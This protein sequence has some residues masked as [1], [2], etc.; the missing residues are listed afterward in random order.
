MLAKRTRKVTRRLKIKSMPQFFDRRFGSRP[1]KLFCAT[2]IF[3]FLLPY[4]A[5]VYKGLTSV[6]AVLLGVDERVCMIVIAL[7]AAAVVVLG[8]YIAT[9]KADFVQGLVML[10]GVSALIVAVV[11]C[12]Q[13]GGLSAGLQAIRR[14]T[15]ELHLGTA[16]H[17]ALGP[18]CS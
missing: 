3:L 1:M 12:K 13:V 4:S 15:A 10:V 16:E 18:P 6:C 9:L 11:R 8:G 5:S 14:A 7:A 17:I 2:V